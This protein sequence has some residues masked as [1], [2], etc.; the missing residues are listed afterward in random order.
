MLKTVA[1]PILCQTIVVGIRV[2]VGLPV[3]ISRIVRTLFLRNRLKGWAVVF[4]VFSSSILA[5]NQ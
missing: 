5:F 2:A 4:L 3:W 1:V